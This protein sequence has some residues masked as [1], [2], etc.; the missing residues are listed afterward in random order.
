MPDIAHD[1]IR[2]LPGFFNAEKLNITM[3]NHQTVPCVLAFLCMFLSQNHLIYL[4][5]QNLELHH[6]FVLMQTQM[7]LSPER[8]VYIHREIL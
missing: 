1:F 2:A 3:V 4:Q 7:C 6:L 8:N 5:S